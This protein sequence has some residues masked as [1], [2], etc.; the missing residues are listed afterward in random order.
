MRVEWLAA[1]FVLM[2]ASLSEAQ[3]CV[4]GDGETSEAAARRREALE[5]A[6]AI[7]SAQWS[8]PGADSGRYLSHAELAS[9]AVYVRPSLRMEPGVDIL[10]GWRLTLDTTAR[11]YWFAITD[12]TD[13][14]GYSFVSNEA[15]HIL[16]AEVI[17]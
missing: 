17:R 11:G 2:F 16:K 4:H 8:Q 12:T 6:R 5:A 9:G 14:C 7:N 3:Q 10:P 1:A 15:G 13:P